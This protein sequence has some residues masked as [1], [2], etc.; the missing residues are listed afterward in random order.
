MAFLVMILVAVAAWVFRPTIGS[1]STAYLVSNLSLSAL[2]ALTGGYSTAALAPGRPRA[3]AMV[4]A[5]MILAMSLSELRHAQPG[6][7][8]WYPAAL[9]VIGP[10]FA[11]CGGMLRRPRTTT[12]VQA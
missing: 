12:L 1:V 9:A 11:M 10:L 8:D 5:L 6:Q 2:A 4:L 3:H 7:P